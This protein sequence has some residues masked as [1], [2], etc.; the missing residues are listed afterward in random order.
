MIVRQLPK[1]IAVLFVAVIAMPMLQSILSEDRQTS[2]LEKRELVQWPNFDEAESLRSYLIH[3]S[4]YAND[5]FGY[6]DSLIAMNNSLKLWLGQSPS[7]SVILGQNDWLF[8][9]IR[10]PLLTESSLTTKE[11]TGNIESRAAYIKQMHSELEAKGV[12]YIFFVAPNKMT[13]YP[14][15]LPN[16]Y[17]LI[18]FNKSY[19]LFKNEFSPES[20]YVMFTDDVLRGNKGLDNDTSLYFKNDTHWNLLGGYYVFKELS[21]RV[22]ALWPNIELGAK[23]HQFANYTHIAGDLANYTGLNDTL[24]AIEPNTNFPKC[25]HRSRHTRLSSGVAL[26]KCDAN[27]TK[28]LSIGDSFMGYVYKYLAESSGWLYTVDQNTPRERIREIVEELQPDLVVEE[29]VERHLPKKLP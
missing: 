5:H 21:N 10:D 19:K 2:L 25:T 13:V 26:I 27:Q 8:L 18:D 11:I 12:G 3:I 29:L 28:I 20:D 7:P 22:N 4:S 9:K 14:E 6:R 17:K 16:I 15:Q 1:F 23:Q 24:R